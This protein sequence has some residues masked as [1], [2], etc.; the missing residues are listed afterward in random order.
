MME[1]VTLYVAKINKRFESVFVES[2][3]MKVKVRNSEQGIDMNLFQKYVNYI[4]ALN[5]IQYI[6]P[7]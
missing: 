1:S 4:W 7:V 6:L 2:L 5:L 3:N